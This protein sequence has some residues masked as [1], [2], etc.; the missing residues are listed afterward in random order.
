[1]TIIMAADLDGWLYL[2]NKVDI[3]SEVEKEEKKEVKKKGSNNSLLVHPRFCFT[4]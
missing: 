4:F 1:M 2:K 3:G